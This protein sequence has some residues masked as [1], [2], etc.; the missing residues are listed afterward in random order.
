MVYIYK[1]KL[2]NKDYY[3][4]RASIRKGRKQITKDIAYLGSSID[5]ARKNLKKE[6]SK[7]QEIRKSYRKINLVLEREYY[8]KKAKEL[9]LKKQDFLEDS[10]EELEACKIHFQ[11]VFRKLD[12]LS[13]KE[14]LEFFAIEFA[15]NTT[16]IEGNTITLEEARNFFETN[17]TPANRSLREIYDLQNTKEVLF[18]LLNEKKEINEKLIIEIHKRLLDKIDKRLRFRT[19]DFRVVKSRFKTSPGAYVKADMKLIL[20]WYKKNK[21]VLHPFVLAS[22]F[23]HKFEKVHPFYD[24]NG[25]TGR[26]LLN[27]IL[28]KNN[29]PLAII[30]KKN[31]E[32]YLEAL[33][34]GDKVGL[35][36]TK[37]EYKEIVEYIAQETIDSYWDI[38]L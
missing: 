1:K 3:Y 17:K 25:R 5:E 18:W 14:T 34:S 32:E 13:Q 29:Y 27:Y 7:K 38:F 24:G 30:K 21:N 26:M 12:R 2:G 36:E 22:I 20:D 16:S 8:Q 11:K 37:Q 19:S 28:I 31:R 15:Y 9:K 33:E 23:H 6:I 35:T 10:L 4:L